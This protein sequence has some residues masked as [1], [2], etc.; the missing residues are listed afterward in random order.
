MQKAGSRCDPTVIP[1]P[2]FSFQDLELH[3]THRMTNYSRM[4]LTMTDDYTH[5][6]G[7]ES[8]ET[9]ECPPL[10]HPQET[11][12]VFDYV[13][14]FRQFSVSGCLPHVR[15]ADHLYSLVDDRDGSHRIA[16]YR[17]CRTRA[18][19]VRHVD[20]GRVKVASSSCKLRW[21]PLCQRSSRYIMGRSIVPFLND[22]PKPK[23]ITLTLK[24]HDISLSEQID[25]LYQS[26]KKLRASKLWK[27]H[28][29]GGVWFFQ[30]KKSVRDGLWHP[31][32]HCL[33][34]GRYLPHQDL[35]AK[36]LMITGDSAIVDIRAVKDKKKTAEYVARYATAPCD[37]KD[38]DD[39]DL[40]ELY[41]SLHGRRV[42]S[43]FGSGRCIQLRP[44]KCPDADQWENI[45]SYFA[46]VNFRHVDPDAA[47]IFEA[48][49]SGGTTDATLER[50]EP[51]PPV[52][53]AAL[54]HEPVTYKQFVFEW[55][56][57]L[58]R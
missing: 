7:H 9:R 36:W 43:T 32:L 37:L 50:E 38:L 48:W 29:R 19:F 27:S 18:W 20:S 56:G 42:C 13:A 40:L 6:Q 54:E 4:D 22:N 17:G 16:D 24:H 14:S 31:H 51:P 46:V 2:A 25:L 3:K 55:S 23:F 10:V 34:V 44:K 39:T 21:C 8:S 53:P 41:D 33:C 1:E 15:R 57:I 49:R 35:S 45:G 11:K 28:I 12:D 58:G 26:F 30:V 47:A 52:D 5:Q